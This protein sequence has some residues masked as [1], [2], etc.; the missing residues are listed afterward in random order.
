MSPISF[1]IEGRGR[2]RGRWDRLGRSVTRPRI[3]VLTASMGAGHDGPARELARRLELRGAEVTVVDLLTVAPFGSV[4]RSWFHRLLVR[5]PGRWGRICATFEQSPELPAAVEYLIRAVGRRIGRII[6]RNSVDLVVSTYLF[7]GRVA[8]GA[9]PCA[10]G[11]VPVVSYLTDP[12]V[13]PV[14]IDD[15]TDLYLATWSFAVPAVQRLTDTPVE[16]V[17]PATREM[18]GAGRA[19]VL[20]AGAAAGH[21]HGKPWALVVSGSWGVGDVVGAAR[22]VLADGRFQ[23]VVVCGNNAELLA[24]CERIPGAIAL[25]WVRDMA[26]LMR[27]CSVAVLNSGGLT[28][29]EAATIGLPVVHHKPLPGQGVMNAVACLSGAGIPVSHTVDELGEA[30]DGAVPVSNLLGTADPVS[31]IWS[32]LGRVPVADGL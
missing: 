14:W 16:L 4:I 29:A 32:L 9:P 31:A 27:D 12:A 6:D 2:G 3:L 17:A 25:G 7:G 13:H 20:G 1:D 18:F 19:S 5:N 10:T 21:P 11:A 22:D 30:L 26:A 28:L 24:E 8:G 23:P 15:V